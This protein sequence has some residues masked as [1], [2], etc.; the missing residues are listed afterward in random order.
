MPDGGGSAPEFAANLN[1]LFTELALP[2]RFAAARDAGFDGVEMLF[3]YAMPAQ[4]LRGH[5]DDTGLDMVLINT[6]AGDWEGKERGFAAVPGAEN[7][8]WQ[9]F[10]MALEYARTTRAHVVHVMAGV[11]EGPQARET[12]IANLR[13]AALAARAQQLTI[14]PINRVDMPG[15]YL[16]GFEQAAGILRDVDMPNLGLQFDAYHA[17]RITGDVMATWARFG[18][19]VR[20]VQIAGSPGRHEPDD[21]EIDFPAFFAALG[22]SGYQGAISAEYFPRGRTEEGLNWLRRI[23]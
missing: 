17:Q 10:E 8:F 2:A 4:A 22:A 12:F 9:G 16:N 21:G 13:R 1:L 14:E 18:P 3:P 19:L 23:R 6:P 20:H 11:A 7:V 15:Y 5:L